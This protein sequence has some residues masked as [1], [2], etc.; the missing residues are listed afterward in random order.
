MYEARI[1]LK[2]RGVVL[3]SKEV[4]YRPKQL[5]GLVSYDFGDIVFRLRDDGCLIFDKDKTGQN[6]DILINGRKVASGRRLKGRF[7]YTGLKAQPV[8]DEEDILNLITER[9]PSVP[10]EGERYKKVDNLYIEMVDGQPKLRV[11]YEEEE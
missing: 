9:V 1:K 8:L 10:P 2:H 4:R 6:K 5:H 3:S 11:V 7:T